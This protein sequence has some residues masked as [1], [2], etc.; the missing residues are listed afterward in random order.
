M[1]QENKTV[2]IPEEITVE[3]LD[4]LVEKLEYYEVQYLYMN[5]SGTYIPKLR[6]KI[7]PQI[8]AFEDL[9]SSYT[10]KHFFE[11]TIEVYPGFNVK[12]RTVPPKSYEKAIEYANQETNG[13]DPAFSRVLARMRASYGIVSLNGQQIGKRMPDTSYLDLSIGDADFA[14]TL[15]ESAVER[16][17]VLA[18]IAMGD[19]LV[20]I[21]SI[22]DSLIS[23]LMNTGDIGEAV[24]NSTRD[25]TN[26][27]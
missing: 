11:Q 6:E 17:G 7:K 19:K 9:I 5:K 3:Y 10:I 22:W 2:K 26:E 25:S 23:E 14:D 12:L 16:Y 24:K 8:P 20:E 1:T 27:L 21:F 15:H 13:R 4:A 18:N